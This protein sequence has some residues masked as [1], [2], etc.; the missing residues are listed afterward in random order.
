MSTINKDTLDIL[1][2][3][4]NWL[5]GY[6]NNRIVPYRKAI[7]DKTLAEA[8]IQ[9]P[10]YTPSDSSGY[11]EPVDLPAAPL[12]E[13]DPAVHKYLDFLNLYSVNEEERLIM[14]M[15]MAIY[16][17]PDFFHPF[18]ENP[19]VMIRSKV[20]R[21]SGHDCVMPTVETAIF[22][23][24]G[25]DPYERMRVLRYFDIGH[26][27]YKNT[28]LDIEPAEDKKPSTY[29]LVSL[30]FSYRSLFL[31]NHYTAPRYSHDFPA[32]FLET[33]LEWDDLKLS[34]QT[35]KEVQ[36][37]VVA[38]KE[39]NYFRSLSSAKHMRKGLRA[40]LY[41]EPGTGKTLTAKLLGKLMYM[42]VARVEISG[43][44]S[45]YVGETNLR[46][47][48]LFNTAEHKNWILFIDEG[49]AILGQ[50]T[51][52]S[53]GETTAHANDTVAFLLQRIE[54]YNGTIVV[55]TNFIDNLDKAYDRRFDISA[56][57]QSLTRDQQ[58]D[59]WMGLIPPEHPLDKPDMLRGLIEKY[60]F[61]P[62]EICNIN[63][64]VLRLMRMEKR[65][66]MPYALIE[67]CVDDTIY[68]QK[69]MK[70]S[71]EHK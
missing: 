59:F 20:Y 55:A 50:R 22:I 57:Y 56:R 43:V 49:D 63:Q 30:N 39:D 62:S 46:L 51:Q 48:S 37:F 40:L 10:Y 68:R 47:E 65:T 5:K 14:I 3:E 66:Q 15:A 41:G 36:E 29:G 21:S 16:L 1:L 58:Y 13:G 60:K 27:F 18:L 7:P 33:D 2:K 70:I 31:Y 61:S 53:K 9:E 71:N 4:L 12:L 8:G 28:I 44:Q 32:T 69:E 42:P 35:A 6:M 24:A 25:E 52:S 26:F 11:N 17:E 38:L 23:L 19:E 45:K 54:S 64:R 67:K 34:P